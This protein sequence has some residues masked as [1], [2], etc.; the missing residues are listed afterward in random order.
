MPLHNVFKPYG[1]ATR[2]DISYNCTKQ[3]AFMLSTAV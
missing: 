2:C 3:V 1:L